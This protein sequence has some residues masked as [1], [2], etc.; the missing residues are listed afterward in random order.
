MNLTKCGWRVWRVDLMG[1]SKYEGIGMATRPCIILYN[2]MTLA[3]TLLQR[4]QVQLLEF[5]NTLVRR[6]GAEN[7]TS[8]PSLNHLYLIN[9]LFSVQ[10]P[11]I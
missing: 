10:T 1:F 7:P 6:V 2:I 3:F 9:V 8:G 5:R 4:P 11:N